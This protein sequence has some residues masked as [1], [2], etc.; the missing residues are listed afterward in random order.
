MTLVTLH[1]SNFDSY[2]KCF[3]PYLENSWRKR[4][5]ILLK[6]F[7][8]IIPSAI[9][10]IPSTYV[11]EF[12][13]RVSLSE[14]HPKKLEIRIFAKQKFGELAYEGRVLRFSDKV[15]VAIMPYLY[16]PGK[17]LGCYG[18]GNSFELI[19]NRQ[20]PVFS[21][22]FWDRWKAIGRNRAFYPNEIYPMCRDVLSGIVKEGDSVLEL[23]GGDGEF[24]TGLLCAENRITKYHLVDLSVKSLLQARKELSDVVRKAPC[25]VTF[26]H[27]D[28]TEDLGLEETFDIVIAIG[29]LTRQVLESKEKSLFALTQAVDALKDGGH[30]ILAG[31]TNSW[32][33]S[34]DLEALDLE[35]LNTY[36]PLRERYIYIAK[37][38]ELRPH[39]DAQISIQ[40]AEGPLR[41]IDNYL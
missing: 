1:K 27:A 17:A 21:L 38:P 25:E 19:D 40:Y 35:V 18:E 31:H 24:A 13:Y 34:T 30:L 37:K 9:P 11:P 14:D 22:S 23:F 12:I 8:A 32:I 41:V 26:H 29:G 4:E 20:Q 36:D 16:N 33:N 10:A 39:D 15:I 28:A 7:G 3:V 6:I 2:S 5:K